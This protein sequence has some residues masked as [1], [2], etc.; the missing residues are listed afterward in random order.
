VRDLHTH[1]DR[2]LEDLLEGRAV[3]NGV[4]DR[5][6]APFRGESQLWPVPLHRGRSLVL[7]NLGY[8]LEATDWSSAQVA[9]VHFLADQTGSLAGARVLDVGSGLGGP[10]I[11]LASD[12]GG[13]VDCFNV[14]EQQVRWTREIIAQHGMPDRVRAHLGSACDMP[15]A[16]GAF[17]VV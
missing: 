12:Y 8:W 9:L 4:L 10:A 5:L 14:V 11:I 15:F 2:R 6:L 16:E 17:D 13:R 1:R 7:V 3:S